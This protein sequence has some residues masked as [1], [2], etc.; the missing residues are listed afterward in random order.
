MILRV[1]CMTMGMPIAS[2]LWP[3]DVRPFCKRSVL[4]RFVRFDE[5]PTH[6]PKQA[7]T[8]SRENRGLPSVTGG[9]PGGDDRSC[10]ADNVAPEVHPAGYCGR[11]LTGDIRTACPSRGDGESQGHEREG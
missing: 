8:G 7:G 5:D 11:E 10:P 4:Q 9:D 2:A 6:G 1:M 3:A